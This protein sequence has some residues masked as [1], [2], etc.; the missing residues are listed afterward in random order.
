MQGIRTVLISFDSFC[1]VP[2]ALCLE[3]CPEELFK[4]GALGLE[5]FNFSENR[6]EELRQNLY[7]CAVLGETGTV[8]AFPSSIPNSPFV[9][10]SSDPNGSSPVVYREISTPFHDHPRINNRVRGI[11]QYLRPK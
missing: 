10:R 5:L 9:N 6:R 8:E 2:Y 11:R 7:E 4:G 3:S 1:L